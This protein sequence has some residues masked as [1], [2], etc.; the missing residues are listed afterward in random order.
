MAGDRRQQPW[1]EML[2]L[3]Y[4]QRIMNSFGRWVIERHSRFCRP[5]F[6]PIVWIGVILCGIAQ[7]IMVVVAYR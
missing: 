5:P 6:I 7:V 4:A 3:S 1:A 2:P